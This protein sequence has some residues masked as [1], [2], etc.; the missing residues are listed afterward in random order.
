M[1][2]ADWFKDNI[3]KIFGINVFD[4]TFDKEKG[5]SVIRK[6]NISIFLYRLDKL[7]KLEKEIIEFT[8]KNY[9]KLIKDNISSNKK[10][11]FAYKEYLNH[12]KINKNLF[13]KL[14]H[15]NGMSHFYTFDEY[16]QYICKWKDKLI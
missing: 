14:I 12:V 1:D 4:Y 5:Y 2:I 11:I 15:N 8:G 10:Y 16:E 3:E 6:D 7:N 13:D 9:F